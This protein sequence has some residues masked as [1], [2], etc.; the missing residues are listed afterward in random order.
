LRQTTGLVREVSFFDAFAF[1]S[2]GMNTGVGFVLL[3]VQGIGFFPGGNVILATVA[4]TLLFAFTATWVYAEFSAAI[5]RSG[6]DYVFASRVLHPAAGWLLSWNNGIWMVFYWIGFNAWFALTNAV[7][8]SL[9]TISLATGQSFWQRLADDLTAKFSIAGFHTEW[10]VVIFGT[11]INLGFAAMLI[12]GSRR[13]W[14]WQKWIF[15]LA[16]VSL[17]LCGVLMA[18]KGRSGFVSSW[19]H[20]AAKNKSLPYNQVIPTAKAAGYRPHAFSI[21]QTFLLFPWV[22]FVVGYGVGTA[23]LGGEVKRAARN[24]YLAMVGGVLVNGLVM[25]LLAVAYFHG[26]GTE[27]AR[28]LSYLSNNAAA[29]LNLPG[30]VQPGF[31]FIASL[32][33]GNVALLLVI[34]LGFVA[35]A[36]MGT[37]LSELQATRYMLA[38]S[39]D[40]TAPSAVGDINERYHT[41]I[42]AIVVSTIAGEIGLFVLLNWTEASLLGA[43][44][45]GVLGLIV[46]CVAGV[47]F[48]F[49]M[50]DTWES[51]GAKRILG[52]PAIAIAGGVGVILLAA[53]FALFVWNKT[54]NGVFGT[55]R[56]V[57]LYF[58]FGVIGVGIV[59]YIGAR[60]LNRRRGIDLGLAFKEI[61]PE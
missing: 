48:P 14:R 55:T 15:G 36:L 61:P 28:S 50:K 23:Q 53:L 38:W 45:A 54:V 27:W 58:T 40:R 43:L 17:I 42:K 19:N 2:L 56:H 25:V 3:L 5:P 21:S 11:L 7:P 37:P 57:S 39:L 12:F 34:G 20:F 8:A 60:L 22:F 31:N 4:A 6:G 49:R 52:V 18:I 1:N 16:G 41:P 30:V 9:S 13:Y 35:W 26:T 47:V 32:L 24:Q 33:T 10:W 29:K 51:A 44:M 46:I 59:W